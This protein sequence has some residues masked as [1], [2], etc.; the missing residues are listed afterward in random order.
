M[1]RPRIVLI[2]AVQSSAA[3]LEAMTAAGADIAAVLTL[4]PDVGQKRH[5]DY[6]DLSVTAA[7]HALPCHFVEEGS[8]IRSL[9][10]SLS[11]D[12]LFVFGWSRLIEPE[13]LAAARL[14][15]VGFHPAPLPVGRGRH[16]LIWTILNGLEKSAVCFFRIGAGAD[17]GDILLRRDFDVAVDETAASIMQKVVSLGCAAVPDLL[18][19]I[20]RRGLSGTPQDHGSAVVWRKRGSHDGR[21]DFRMSQKMIDR[22]VRAL[23]RPYP[24]ADAEH[25]VAGTGKVFRVEVCER[26]QSARFAEPGRV[27]GQ[28]AGAPLVACADGAVLLAEHGFGN[29]IGPGSWFQ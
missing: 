8:D 16:P 26:P 3:L 28:M 29:S 5:S 12:V 10:T 7:R 23:S 24:G 11:P 1:M 6:A 27:V 19:H 13:T 14:G 2:G 21:I 18:S 25:A 9:I 17:D 15:A 20:E 22:L 4:R